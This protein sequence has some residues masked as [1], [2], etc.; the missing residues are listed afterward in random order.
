MPAYL[1]ALNTERCA[2]CGMKATFK[3][4][5]ERNALIG[6]YCNHH[7]ERAKARHNDELNARPR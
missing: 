4:Y 2:N 3:L 7:A 1:V 6:Y 5:N